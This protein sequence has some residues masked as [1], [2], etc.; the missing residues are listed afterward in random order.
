MKLKIRKKET[1][2]FNEI[3]LE[4]HLNYGGNFVLHGDTGR[5]NLYKGRWTK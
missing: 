3:Y 5:S 2:E 1:K 4:E